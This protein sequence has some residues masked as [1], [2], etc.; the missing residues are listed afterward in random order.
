[1]S[2]SLSAPFGWCWAV[3]Q[4]WLFWLAPIAGAVIGAV[5]YRYISGVKAT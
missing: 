1:M 4:L 5:I 2:R 3:M